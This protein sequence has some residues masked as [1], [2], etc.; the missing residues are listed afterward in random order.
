MTNTLEVSRQLAPETLECLSGEFVASSDQEHQHEQS[1]LQ[2][3]DSWK[4]KAALTDFWLLRHGQTDSNRAGRWQG[5]APSAPPLNDTGRAQALAVRDQLKGVEF[6][7][8]YPSDLLRSRQTAE[9]IA[10]CLGLPITLEP[11][12]REMNLGTWEGMLSDEIKAKFSREVAERARDPLNMRAPQGE[13]PKEVAERVIPAMVEIA[14]KH[15]E[16]SVLIVAHGMPLARMSCYA[17]GIPL[18]NVYENIPGNAKPF[19]LKWK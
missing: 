17:Q 7:A 16:K 15:R 5:Q 3:W 13:S 11:R 6:A 4:A 8:I 18:H 19:R 14:A 9:L 1:G 12:L 10:E 2:F